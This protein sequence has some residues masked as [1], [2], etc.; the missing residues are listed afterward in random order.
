MKSY[1]TFCAP[2]PLQLG[3]AA[4]LNKIA[5][6]AEAEGVS[7]V[8]SDEAAA[9][10]AENV[11][12]LSLALT[13]AG[14]RVIRPDGGYFLVADVS[15]LGLTSVEYCKQLAR[16][17]GGVHTDGRLRPGADGESAGQLREVRGV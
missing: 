15:D 7:A 1:T 13:D 11:R 4:A 16:G 8:T 2:T 14:L 5:D 9:A 17:E 6:D 3:V 12:V 10:M